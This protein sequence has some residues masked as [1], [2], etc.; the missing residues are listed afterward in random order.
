MKK[1]SFCVVIFFLAILINHLSL[2]LTYS[3]DVSSSIEPKSQAAHQRP[4]AA[5]NYVDL[6]NPEDEQLHNLQGWD[7]INPGLLPQP[8]ADDRTSRYQTPRGSSSVEL[9]VPQAGMAY[10]LVFRTEDGSADDS[11]DVYVN[12][13]G[14]VYKYRH[15]GAV[16]QGYPLHQVNVE[17]SLITD[18]TVKVRFKNRAHD[19]WGRA[20]VYF[21]AL[22]SAAEQMAELVDETRSESLA[23][24]AGARLNAGLQNAYNAIQVGNAADA[25]RE[26][27][28]STEEV[29]AMSGGV[30]PVE[31]AIRIMSSLMRVKALVGCQ[32]IRT[33]HSR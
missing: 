24:E 33:E 11:F 18:R 17:A 7:A 26:L 1:L 5:D 20:A 3:Q 14:P 8:T 12:D 21:V 23:P 13:Q 28:R 30:I 32:S 29:E 9:F 10:T 2:P 22:K 4:A 6:G 19:D 16:G 15:G 27:S 25:C 31:E